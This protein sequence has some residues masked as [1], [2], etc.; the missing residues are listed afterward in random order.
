MY[1]GMAG[2]I[3]SSLRERHIANINKPK[4]INNVQSLSPDHVNIG[5]G[6][7]GKRLTIAAH[8]NGV[9]VGKYRPNQ[10]ADAVKNKYPNFDADFEDVRLISCHGADGG[11]NAYGQQL[12]N[13][14]K[15]P[16]KAYK[17]ILSSY[18]PHWTIQQP[19]FKPGQSSFV[20]ITKTTI[21]NN[22]TPHK[23]APVTFRPKIRNA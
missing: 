3:G 9:T 14:L 15:K 10:L 2:F 8:G 6:E 22:G 4:K 21:I 1:A 5:T 19:S 23:Y 20:H 13:E 17:G 11:V 12:A 7:Q 18:S 16:V